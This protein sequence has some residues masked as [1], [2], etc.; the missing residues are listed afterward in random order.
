MIYIW[1]TYSVCLLLVDGEPLHQSLGVSRLLNEFRL[2]G[3][4]LH[5][6]VVDQ[7]VGLEEL[8]QTVLHT[9][10]GHD[11]LSTSHTI[12][13]RH[14]LTIQALIS[15]FIPFLIMKHFTELFNFCQFSFLMWSDQTGGFWVKPLSFFCKVECNN[16][17]MHIVIRWTNQST[18][19]FL[20]VSM[21]R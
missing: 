14:Q 16:L 18:Y 19:F 3:N 1:S 13:N 9:V 17:L 12:H 4:Q 15:I 20:S 6:H 11:Q 10:T 21:D 7:L 8:Q 2:Q 5:L